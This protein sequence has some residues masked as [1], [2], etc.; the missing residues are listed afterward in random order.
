M[1]NLYT[2]ADAELTHRLLA[3]YYILFSLFII[4][5]KFSCENFIN[6]KI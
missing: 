2:Y 1:R 4:L 6:L 3:L 5:K